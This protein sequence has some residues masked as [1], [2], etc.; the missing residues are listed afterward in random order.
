MQ[1]LAL[2]VSSDILTYFR[3]KKTALETLMSS[4]I[5]LNTPFFVVN[6]SNFFILILSVAQPISSVQ[7][8][9]N[10][11]KQSIHSKHYSERK[12][13]RFANILLGI[14][15]LAVSLILFSRKFIEDVICESYLPFS[16]EIIAFNQW[17]ITALVKCFLNIKITYYSV[18]I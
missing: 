14:I 9:Q 11:L 5:N 8:F 10:N 1:K 2:N 6:F 3:T 18:L 12:F 15:Y 16:S 13:H 4:A 17:E 7:V